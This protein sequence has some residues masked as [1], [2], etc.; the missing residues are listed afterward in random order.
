VVST[1]PGVVHAVRSPAGHV[2]VG[3]YDVFVAH[4]LGL[5]A[6]MTL[7]MG[8]HPP[9]VLAFLIDVAPGPGRLRGGGHDA[10]VG[11]LWRWPKSRSGTRFSS[12]MDGKMDTSDRDAA[13]ADW[14]GRPRGCPPPPAMPPP[15]APAAAAL[16]PVLRHPW[17]RSPARFKRSRPTAVNAPRHWSLATRR[18]GGSVTECGK[19][20]TDMAATLRR[21]GFDVTY[22]R[23]C[24]CRRWK[25]PCRRLTC[26]C[27]RAYGPVLLCRHGV[28]VDG[29]NYLLPLNAR[30]ERQQ[31]V[32]YQALPW[33][34]LWGRWRMRVMG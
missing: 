7:S 33:A 19:D 18:T 12:R 5:A 20:A 13:R 11:S 9:S 6:L 2:V 23:M 24:P 1:A 22:C 8:A 25:K 31:D 3:V 34:R 17:S 28:Q 27:A 32:R 4:L 30:I 10:P 16:P 15:A 21:L 14:H 29:E 26:G